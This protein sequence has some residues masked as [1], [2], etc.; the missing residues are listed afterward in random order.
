MKE[1]VLHKFRSHLAIR[2]SPP[3]T[4]VFLVVATGYGPLLWAQSLDF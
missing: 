3:W 4:P 2:F 1:S